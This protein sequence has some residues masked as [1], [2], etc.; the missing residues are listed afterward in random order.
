MKKTKKPFIILIVLVFSLLVIGT[1]GNNLKAEDDPGFASG[2]I[3]TYVDNPYE[4]Y[5]LEKQ[6]YHQEKYQNEN[7]FPQTSDIVINASDYYGFGYTTETNEDGEKIVEKI[8][9]ND[10]RLQSYEN[11]APNAIN[12]T[13]VLQEDEGTIT[14]KVNVQQSGFYNI[15]FRYYPI[16]GYSSAIERAIAI[17]GEV[18]FDSASAMAFSRIWADAETGYTLDENG[19]KVFKADL[20]G[21]ATKPQQ[22]E[23]RSFISAYAKDAMGYVTENFKFYLEQGDSYISFISVKEPILLD[24]MTIKAVQQNKTYAEY[25]AEMESLHGSA[26]SSAKN[27]QARVEGENTYTKSSPTL[28]PGTDRSS[29][30]TTPF[31]YKTTVLNVIGGDSWSTVGDW[32]TWNIDVPE[33]GFYN[34]SMRV[35]QNTVKGMYSTRVV[36]VNDEILFDELNSIIF[37]YSNK[38]YNFTLG[39]ENGDFLIYLKKG[40]NTL[41]MEVSLGA[42]STLIE[43]IQKSIDNLSA[44]YREII[45]YT[46]VNPDKNRD[47]QLEKKFPHMM[48]QFEEY[49]NELRSISS[50]IEAISGTKNDKTGVIDAVAVQIEDFLERPGTIPSRLG[51]FST[52]ISSL[53]TILLDLRSAPLEV[54][55]ISAH[56]EDIELPK[57]NAGFFRK[58]WDGIVSF[59]VSFFIDYSAIGA[60]V[61]S[62]GS[63]TIQ[64]WMTAGR[65]QANVI[66]NLIDTDFRKSH[67]DINVELKLTGAD[68]LLKATLA[69]IGPEVALNVDSTLPVNYG[70]RN[71]VLDL[72]TIDGFWDSIYII[73]D[74]SED[75]K[76]AQ[77]QGYENVYMAS[78]IRQ[79]QFSDYTADAMFD[80]TSLSSIEYMKENITGVYALPEKQ[81]FLMMFVRDDVLKDLGLQDRIPE[82]WDDVIDLVAELQAEQLQF[83]LPV[84][85]AGATA[86]NPIFV[87]M[88]YQNG[89]QLYTDDNRETA[90]LSEPAMDAFEYWTEFYTLYSFPKSASFVN[91]FRTGEMP[92]G[93]SYYDLYNT[94]SVSAPELKGKWSFHTIPG[95]ERTYIDEQGNE[96][97]YIDHTSTTS[98]SA[99]VILKAPAMKS[100]QAKM[101]SWEFLKWW[102]SANIQAQ[103]GR[104]MEGILGAAARHN[105]ANVIALQELSW[106][107]N[108]LNILMKQWA[109]THEMPN[110]AGS[111]MTGREIE[112]AYRQV[113]NNLINAREVLYEYANKINN[114][115]DRKRSEFNLPLRGE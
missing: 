97:T 58:L 64:V 63:R 28:Y 16:E 17:N 86:L 41:K 39:D 98:G 9:K 80:S 83:Y 104:E 82:T 99:C 77:S 70:L 51:T 112:N 94:L 107:A 81:N 90:L 45:A 87:T 24:T 15:V 79:Y 5:I 10:K 29:S 91:R 31:S 1:I 2:D 114:E 35:K 109:N 4:N 93:I 37:P 22:V 30:K 84:N 73:P 60:T 27:L 61:E 21:N 85:D 3:S 92:I 42:Y 108:E 43:R 47:Y 50:A 105:T 67:P 106:T 18:P 12:Q 66:R 48:G 44:L 96:V 95:T 110:I 6:Q 68:V 55:Y 72:T 34:I 19:N 36:Y 100:E 20:N 89:G 59:F 76:T 65:D 102:T 49:K 56:T 103:F 57:A 78:S 7:Y 46:T 113:I 26:A 11:L 40:T 25:L 71:A 23:K 53:G 74:G 13:L 38:W 88:L 62:T 101:D 52:N 54:D 14:W 32:I 33:D 115:I 75:F 8:D 69:G 111:Y